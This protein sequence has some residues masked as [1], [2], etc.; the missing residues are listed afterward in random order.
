MA[1]AFNVSS[2][3]SKQLVQ[4]LNAKGKLIHTV[5][6]SYSKDFTQ[7]KYTPGTTVSMDI[8]HQPSVTQGRVANV[9]DVENRT[10]SVTIGQWNSAESFTSIEKGYSMDNE[11]DVKRYAND[12]AARLVRQIELD[13]FT[14]MMKYTGNNVGTPGVDAGSL[15]TWAEGRAKIEDALGPDR[16]CSA[17]VNPMGHVA[18]TDSL[19]GA[20]NPGK[21]ISN[22]YLSGKM[23][24]AAGMNFYSSQSIARQTAGTTDDFSLDIDGTIATEGSTTLVLSLGDGG[25]ETITAGTKLTVAG[26]F[27]VDPQSKTTLSYLKQ[28][29]VTA[30]ATTAGAAITLEVSP[31]MYSSGSSHQNLSQFPQDAAVVTIVNSGT[32]S[33]V[34]AQNVI[35]DKDAY[36]LVSVPLPPAR[37]GVHTYGNV[38]G[39]Q[40]RTGVGSWDAVNDD[41]ILRVDIAYGWGTLRED[42]ACIVWGD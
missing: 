1:N 16:D 13:G 41:Q 32:A 5:N 39:I 2:L 25:T 24:N 33:T 27:A 38:N 20:T 26:V 37:G 40:I 9:Q 19:K 6:Q 23:K 10:S 22:Q 29:S 4:S 12:M 8:Q 18:L 11:K 28:F 14:H 31:P 30:L 7:K 15:R 3:V 34:D 21:T 35:Y 42:H 36:T 17:A